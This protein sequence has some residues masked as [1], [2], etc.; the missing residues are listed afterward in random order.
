ME[1]AEHTVHIGV[2]Y[3]PSAG[4]YS[5]RRIHCEESFQFCYLFINRKLAFLYVNL[6]NETINVLN[7]N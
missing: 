4:M 5:G 1:I 3:L 2:L 7:E 6:N